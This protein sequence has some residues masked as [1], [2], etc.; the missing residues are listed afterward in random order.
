MNELQLRA[1][2]KHKILP[3]YLRDS[4]TV[5][6]EELAL[7][8]AAARIDL[9]VVNS[10][11]HGFELKSDSDTLERLADQARAYS[12]VFDRITLIVGYRHAYQALGIVPDWWGVKLAH[13]GPRGGIHFSD[14]RSARNNPSRNPVALARLLWRQEALSLLD[15]ID[16]AEGFR[17]KPSASICQRLVE[18]ASLDH[19]HCRVRQRLKQRTTWRFAER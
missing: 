7:R 1:A 5:I 14:A 9:V 11:L 4:E 13:V 15:E 2:V 6:L 8:H 17:S 3:R 18:V 10:I 16:E 19:L 12:S